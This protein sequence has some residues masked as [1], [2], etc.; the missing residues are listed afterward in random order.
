[1][2]RPKF[3]LGSWAFSFG[4]FEKDPWSF[5]AFLA[6]AARA[7]YDGVEINGFHP[8]P[9]PDVYDTDQKR[10]QLRSIVAAHGLGI[11]G[12]A[13]DFREVPP[14]R[15]AP[16]DYLKALAK[17][18][19]FCN[20][21]EIGVVRVDSISPP[22]TLEANEYKRRFE[23]LATTWRAAADL[24]ASG[25]V[26]L[27][28]EFEPGFWLNRPSEIVALVERVDHP[29]FKV[30]FDTSHA[31]MCSETG[32]RHPGKRE[33]LDGGMLE[34]YDRLSGNIGHFHLIDSDGTLH[35]EETSTHA[36][37]GTGKIEFEKVLAAMRG[38]VE[39]LEWWCFDFC[40]CPTTERDARRAIPF[41]EGILKQLS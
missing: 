32:A 20:S 41:V 7:G 17:S 18:V 38:D 24:C 13:P 19:A 4:P 16:S 25:G 23:R 29:N 2:R 10:R 37:F 11:S 39:K 33:I 34:L 35:G 36:P 30:L 8:H 40:F 3:S 12:Y 28:W 15:V 22:E 31:Y 5:E 9:H 26:L 14:A 21:L 6:Y 1:M 27:V